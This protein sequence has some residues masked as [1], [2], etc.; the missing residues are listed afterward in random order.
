[1]QKR[2]RVEGSAE[3]G[4]H[5]LIMK[6]ISI[7]CSFRTFGSNATHMHTHTSCAGMWDSSIS[8]F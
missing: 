3:M 7:I 5:N 6:P 1:M 4:K 2:I 8:I